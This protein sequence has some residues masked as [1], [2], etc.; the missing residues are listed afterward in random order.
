MYL[1]IGVFA[2]GAGVSNTELRLYEHLRRDPTTKDLSNETLAE[3]VRAI[4]D[5]FTVDRRPE[6]TRNY[7]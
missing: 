4:T 6:Y 1:P 2:T 7:R 5:R 3:L